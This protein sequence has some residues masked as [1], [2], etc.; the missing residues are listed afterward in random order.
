[1]GVGSL[2]LALDW[3]LIVAGSAFS[4]WCALAF[5]IFK[6]TIW[7]HYGLALALATSLAFLIQVVRIRT[8]GGLEK[9]KLQNNSH[10]KMLMEAIHAA[11]GA[12]QRFRILSEASGEGVLLHADGKIIDANLAATRLFG[13]DAGEL[14]GKKLIDLVSPVYHHVIDCATI[15]STER[16]LNIYGLRNNRSL[17]PMRLLSN[18]IVIQYREIIVTR[19]RKLPADKAPEEPDFDTEAPENRLRQ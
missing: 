17:F 19:V 5:V 16:A 18:S 10:Q 1:L 9:L 11:R 6:P 7:N 8:I 12:E 14:I 3:F 13:Y 4:A 2:F 15:G